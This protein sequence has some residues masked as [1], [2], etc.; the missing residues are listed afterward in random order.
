MGADP[1]NFDPIQEIEAKVG[2]GLPGVHSFT[3]PWYQYLVVL[4]SVA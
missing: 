1:V 3:T 4:D 2:G